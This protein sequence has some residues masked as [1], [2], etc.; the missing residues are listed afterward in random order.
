MIYCV[1]VHR[2]II[3]LSDTTG[4]NSCKLLGS[5]DSSYA[6]IQLECVLIQRSMVLRTVTHDW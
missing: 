3:S 2:D 5:G 1:H 4:I 6:Y